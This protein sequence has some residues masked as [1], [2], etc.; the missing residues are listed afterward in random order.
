MGRKKER[1]KI[2]YPQEKLDV[3][4]EIKNSSQLVTYALSSAPKHKRPN[5]ENYKQ[6]ISDHVNSFQLFKA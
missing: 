6:I 4:E 5:T 3:Y 1:T 2:A